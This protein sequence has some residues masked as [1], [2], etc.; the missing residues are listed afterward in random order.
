VRGAEP[1]SA[2]AHVKANKVTPDSLKVDAP[3]AAASGDM[4]TTTAAPPVPPPAASDAAPA[5]PHGSGR[6]GPKAPGATP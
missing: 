1:L 2:G 5:A 6:R 3:A 4:T